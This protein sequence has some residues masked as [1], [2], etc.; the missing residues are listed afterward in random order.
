MRVI[1]GIKFSD[2]TYF[3]L[4]QFSVKKNPSRFIESTGKENE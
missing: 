4:Y 1:A 3:H 2:N